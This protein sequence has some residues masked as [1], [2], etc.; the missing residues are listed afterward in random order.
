VKQQLEKED[1]D[2]KKPDPKTSCAST[3]RGLFYNLTMT[4]CSIK[5][6]EETVLNIVLGKRKVSAKPL[7]A[8]L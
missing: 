3:K 7:A 6:I 2:C 5:H 1:F 8:T 4:F